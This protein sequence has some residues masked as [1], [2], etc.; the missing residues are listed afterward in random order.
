M[1]YSHMR[2]TWFN[3]HKCLALWRTVRTPSNGKPITSGIRMYRLDSYMPPDLTSTANPLAS[4]CF[5]FTRH[6]ERIAAQHTD[7]LEVLTKPCGGT[8]TV[9]Y[10]KFGL[11]TFYVKPGVYRMAHM[12]WYSEN[13]REMQSH[14]ERKKFLRTLPLYHKGI[15]FDMVTGRCLNPKEE[16]PRLVNKEVNADWRRRY[17]ALNRVWRVMAKCG[18]FEERIQSLR[19]HHLSKNISHVDMLIDA[20]RTGH[21]C[22]MLTDHALHSAMFA[23]RWHQPQLT[24]REQ[25][26]ALERFY[27]T[28]RD[29]VRQK[30]GCFL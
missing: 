20:V 26:K 30:V 1:T 24:V 27:A 14:Y 23:G 12:G 22:Q 17:S 18:A 9:L 16:T 6:G 3:Y 8:G 19:T 5:V 7:S 10:N 25:E 11:V 2:S 15:K 13:V 4:C 21:P 29:A 28:Y